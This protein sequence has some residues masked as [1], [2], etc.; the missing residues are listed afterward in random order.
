MEHKNGKKVAKRRLVP[1]E[2]VYYEA[3]RSRKDAENREYQL[4]KY[5]NALGHLKR[6]ISDS[7]E[8]IHNTKCGGVQ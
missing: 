8:M 1:I 3:Y 2:L 6:R 5:G 7:L 4:K